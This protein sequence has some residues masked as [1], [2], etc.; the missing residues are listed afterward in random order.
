MNFQ[1]REFLQRSGMGLAAAGVAGL[2]LRADA[3]PTPAA[4]DADEEAGR[5]LI[6]MGP[7]AQESAKAAGELKKITPVVYGPWYRQGAP[8][9]GKLCPPPRLRQRVLPPP[10]PH[11]L[12]RFQFRVYRPCRIR[13]TQRRGPTPGEPGRHGAEPQEGPQAATTVYGPGRPAGCCRS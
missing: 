2:V 1:R 13:R 5:I 8:F 4:A 3:L 10:Q 11:L 12:L 9:R 7:P 6:Q